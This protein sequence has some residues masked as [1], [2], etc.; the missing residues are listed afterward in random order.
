MTSQRDR[1]VAEIEKKMASLPNKQILA[2]YQNAHANLVD[3]FY[4]LR[5]QSILLG[6]CLKARFGG[7]GGNPCDD[8]L[9]KGLI[10]K[11]HYELIWGLT[12]AYQSI[13]TLIQMNWSAIKPAMLILE[14]GCNS[15]SELFFAI[16]TEHYDMRLISCKDGF[17]FTPAHAKNTATALRKKTSQLIIDT[18]ADELSVD[19][20]KCGLMSNR[21]HFWLL[22]VLSIAKENLTS[23]SFLSSYYKNCWKELSRLAD[24]HERWSSQHRNDRAS[25]VRWKNGELAIGV[26]GG[27]RS[28]TELY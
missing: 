18:L 4:R 21:K 16:L 2:R 3:E 15:E 13:F 22:F 27:Y 12:D 26:R 19:K 28:V 7:G 23:N 1:L 9:R 25:A 5:H 11:Y 8:P 14:D 17:S 6:K 20:K 10:D 24:I